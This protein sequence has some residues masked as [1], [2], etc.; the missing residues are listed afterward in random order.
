MAYLS[1]VVAGVTAYALMLFL[2]YAMF[3]INPRED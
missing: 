2:A 3:A 1:H